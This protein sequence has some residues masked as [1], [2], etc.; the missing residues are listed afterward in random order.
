M[1][2]NNNH[3]FGNGLTIYG[4]LGDGSLL[5]YPHCV[6][7][8]P[9]LSSVFLHPSPGNAIPGTTRPRATP[10]TMP[11]THTRQSTPPS[12]AV[13]C[14]GSDVKVPGKKGVIL[15]TTIFWMSMLRY[16]LF[17]I[18]IKDHI[19]IYIEIYLYYHT[20][21]NINKILK[22]EN[23]HCFLSPPCPPAWVH[24]KRQ[25]PKEHRPQQDSTAT[26]VGS[27][28]ERARRSL[29]NWEVG[30]PVGSPGSQIYLKYIHTRWGPPVISWLI[31]PI[32]YSYKY[33]KP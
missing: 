26:T 3:P 22:R 13:W 12:C 14:H 32:N 19:Y 30:D 2:E 8:P 6:R 5:F 9:H 24:H 15:E 28:K 25:R 29:S 31:N 18:I 21:N 4:D 20:L 10:A 16:D 27:A 1:W 23:P 17:W 7:L 33:H 11:L